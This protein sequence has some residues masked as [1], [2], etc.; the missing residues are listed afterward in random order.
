MLKALI[1]KDSPFYIQ[2]FISKHCNL[3]CRM[4]NMV[5]STSSSKPFDTEQIEAI[6]RNLVKIGAGVVL[7]TGG[8]P[9][10][11]KDIHEIVRIFKGLKLDVRMQT[12]GL[13]IK[14]D[15]LK[16]C[17]DAGARD[18]NVSL[19][20]LDEA[21]ADNINGVEGSFKGTLKAISMISNTFPGKDS[22]CALGCVLSRYNMK[23]IEPILEFATSIGWWL[24]LV[25][26][27]INPEGKN[28][29]FRG[30]DRS[31]MFE[32]KDYP[33]LKELIER[34]KAMKRKGFNLFDSDNFLDSIYHFST[35]GQPDWLF[36]RKHY[37]VP[38][39]PLHKWQP[40]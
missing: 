36:C 16:K 13:R 28:L 22:I 30:H 19:D 33:Y 34:L 20:S 27:H 5:E 40:S 17:V 4:C 31:F 12:A 6:G 11:R 21:L 38:A 25:P 1:T 3:N 24:S 39:I 18:I 8:E 15:I 29:R 2:F 23:E 37:N 9:F 7:L 10:L 14:E 35:T 32:E 26:V